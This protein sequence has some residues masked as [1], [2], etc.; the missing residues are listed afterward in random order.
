[1]EGLISYVRVTNML[2]PVYLRF[3]RSTRRVVS[4]KTM[5]DCDLTVFWSAKSCVPLTLLNA[6]K[7]SYINGCLKLTPVE[8]LNSK[9]SSLVASVDW[10]PDS[11]TC[12]L[13]DGRLKFFLPFRK[14]Y[15]SLRKEFLLRL[16][17]CHEMSPSHP[18]CI[19]VYHHL[20]FSDSP[21]SDFELLNSHVVRVVVI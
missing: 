13:L 20:L 9:K 12:R 6:A 17:H 4:R 18:R 15:C 14:Q 2:I 7:A 21:L 16:P 19:V 1:M 5:T 3:G 8:E 10:D 11:W